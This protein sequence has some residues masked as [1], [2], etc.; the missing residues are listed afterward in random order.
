M[1]CIF[2]HTYA[3]IEPT[4]PRDTAAQGASSVAAASRPGELLLGRDSRR[5]PA[6]SV[7]SAPVVRSF[8]VVSSDA[9]IARPGRKQHLSIIRPHAVGALG[10]TSCTSFSITADLIAYVNQ[11]SH[12]ATLIGASGDRSGSRA[13]PHHL[14][15]PRAARPVCSCGQ[16][17]QPPH[18][19]LHRGTD[20]PE[21]HLLHCRPISGCSTH[22]SSR[23]Q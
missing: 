1:E 17:L 12:Q 3:A 11:L 9:W 20:A 15:R 2:G 8:E 13:S 10:E 7:G 16:Q 14:A 21:S 23:L 19:R 22:R 18:Q 4:P 5:V 6:T